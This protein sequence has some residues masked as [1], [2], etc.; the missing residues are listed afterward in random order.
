MRLALSGLLPW[1]T[2][3]LTG[4]AKGART[5]EG[6]E[7]EVIFEDIFKSMVLLSVV[8][9]QDPLREGV[10]EAVRTCQKAGV[11]VRMVTG[12]NLITARAIAASCGI[13]TE[14]GVIMEGPAFRKLSK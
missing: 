3:I 4:P 5:V 12:D 1:Y 9:I 7:N 11:V 6:E 2:E 13:F 10:P 8:G 14:G